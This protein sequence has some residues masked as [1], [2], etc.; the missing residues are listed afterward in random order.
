M[1]RCYNGQKFIPNQEVGVDPNAFTTRKDVPLEM[2][3]DHSAVFSSWEV[4]GAEYEAA[5]ADLPRLS[6]FAGRL[7]AGPALV[8]DWIAEYS[9]QFRRLMKLFLFARMSNSVDT[10]DGEAKKSLAQVMG[11]Q[12]R[13]NAA[14][15]FAIP[16]F[17][18][19]GDTVLNWTET[20]IGLSIYR[21]FIE[22]I[23]RQKPHRRS[24]EIEALLSSL[25]DPFT[26]VSQTAR[27][28]TNSD[29]KFVP[30]LDSSGS[31]QP[32]HQATIPPTGIESSDRTHRRNAWES[33]ADGYRS[34]ENTLASNYIA[35]VKQFVFLARAR[36]YSS[37]LEMRL[38]SANLPVEVFYNLIGV[39][40]QNLPVWHRYWEVKR[41]IL[42]VDTLHPYDVWAPIVTN[43]PDIS[44]HRAVDWIS[45]SLGPLGEDYVTILRRGCLPRTLG[46]LC[47][48]CHQ[49]ARCGIFLA[50]RC[51][52]LHLHDL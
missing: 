30:A 34:V 4:W 19:L 52:S 9:Q 45:A 38:A 20:E 21:H 24:A 46:R 39:F 25:A 22:N 35:A 15:S 51:S 3:W 33:F 43:P 23:L 1:I 2:T 40:K 41:R 29:L 6:A 48:Q 37:V 50:F 10:S 11:L 36:N 27:E 18:A 5:E 44:F 32:V 28:L 7:Q 17:L 49:D 26:A 31:S 8:L 16:E 13:F 12:A 14:N 42:G 47:P